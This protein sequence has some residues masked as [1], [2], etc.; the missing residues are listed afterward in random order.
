M[1]NLLRITESTGHNYETEIIEIKPGPGIKVRRLETTIS[2]Y[3]DQD[4]YQVLWISGGVAAVTVDLQRVPFFPNTI[5]FLIPGRIINLEFSD[6]S[7][8]G[9]ILNFSRRFFKNQN[10]EGLNIRNADIFHGYGDMPR[11]VLSPKIGDRV[12]SIAEMI[13]EFSGSE[14]PNKEVAI[15]ALLRTLLVY[16]DS[17]CNIKPAFGSNRQDLNIVSLFKYHVSRNFLKYHQVS[18][19]AQLMNI[20]PKYLNQVVKRVMGVTAKSV[21]QEQLLIQAS[22]DLKFS[23]ESIKEIAFKLGFAESEHFSN[24]FKK[25]TGKTPS[26]FRD[27]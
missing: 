27:T 5:L 15:S 10:L 16:C 22:R 19:Y 3:T 2:D 8:Q 23:N 1:S 6:P 26:V 21:I 13:A 9:W 12:H 14:I 7:P 20:T 17:K 11:I 24:F 25:G 18:Q 4:N